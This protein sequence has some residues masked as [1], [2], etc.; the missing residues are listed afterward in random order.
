MNRGCFWSGGKTHPVTARLSQRVPGEANSAYVEKIALLSCSLLRSI[1][2]PSSLASVRSLFFSLFLRCLPRLLPS[3][4]VCLFWSHRNGSFRFPF[5]GSFLCP[6]LDWWWSRRS[7]FPIGH[8]VF[9]VSP[10]SN[11]IANRRL[12]LPRT[13]LRR[14]TR[15]LSRQSLL[16]LLR[17]PSRRLRSSG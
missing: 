14:P 17:P 4:W 7:M 11:W 3:L 13:L 16:Y 9:V 5:V 12:P 1:L 8:S 6:G 15:R 2:P 10:R